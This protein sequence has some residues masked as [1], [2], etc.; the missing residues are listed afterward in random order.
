MFGILKTRSDEDI[1]LTDILVH[2]TMLVDPDNT[3][4]QEL[5]LVV[6]RDGRGKAKTTYQSFDSRS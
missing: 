6:F 2:N 1:F 3:V 4:Q 5:D